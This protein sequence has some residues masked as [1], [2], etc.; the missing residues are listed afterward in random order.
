MSAGDYEGGGYAR[1]SS[2]GGRAPARKPQPAPNFENMD[3]DIP[4]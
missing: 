4:F 2:G 3:D 1:E